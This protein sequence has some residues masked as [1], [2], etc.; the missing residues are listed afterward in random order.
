LSKRSSSV[1]LNHRNEPVSEPW[2]P[3]N[4]FS[5]IWRE[6]LS[7]VHIEVLATLELV[8]PMVHVSLKA[9]VAGVGGSETAYLSGSCRPMDHVS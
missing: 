4:H 5:R 2:T 3:R 1:P 8:R 9:I 7:L 6:C